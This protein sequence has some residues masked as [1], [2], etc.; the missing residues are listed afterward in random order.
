[1]SI[2][3][4][5]EQQTAMR[6]AIRSVC[7]F[8]V[9]FIIVTSWVNLNNTNISALLMHQRSS[10]EA[11]FY[12][13]ITRMTKG[14]FDVDP[15]MFFRIG[16]YSYGFPYFFLNWLLTLPAQLLGR[17][18]VVIFIMRLFSSL[19]VAGF[20]VLASWWVAKR[21]EDWR[22]PILTAL[23]ILALPELWTTAVWIHP[24]LL[25]CFCTLVVLVIADCSSTLDRPRTLL[26]IGVLFAIAVSTKLQAVV[27]FPAVAVL[28]IWPQGTEGWLAGGVRSTLMR[29]GRRLLLVGTTVVVAYPL[30]NPYLFHPLGR[31]YFMKSVSSNLFAN[32]TNNGTYIFPSLSEK[33]EMLGRT[34]YPF[35]L[36]IFIIA[37]I[38][39]SQFLPGSN[40]TRKQVSAL[41]LLSVPVCIY[42]LATINKLWPHYYLLPFMGVAVM[43]MM[44]VGPLLRSAG[45]TV[46]A[47]ALAAVIIFVRWQAPAAAINAVVD[48][49]ATI[50]HSHVLGQTL[51]RLPRPVFV[52]SNGDVPIPFEQLGLKFYQI[53]EMAGIEI[54]TKMATMPALPDM[55]IFRKDD[56]EII[57]NFSNSDVPKQAAHAWVTN[58]EAGLDRDYLRC[59]ET[60]YEKIL[61]YPVN[62]D[63]HYMLG[64]PNRRSRVQR[65]SAPQPRPRSPAMI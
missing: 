56:P 3:N 35:S 8:S 63:T 32:A 18:D 57:G 21:T 55:V 15:S 22:S 49:S 13:I 26:M 62:A 65:R 7:F 48:D 37:G 24:D 17:S 12:F 1:M 16:F 10:D 64:A 43:L 42:M 29:V 28:L 46:I 31:L 60:E 33:I 36:T 52:L 25:M 4:N 27:F 11:E 58:V 45:G 61:A 44:A 34:Y 47:V 54:T 6:W 2:V 23:A 41:F 53:Y 20:I 30:L 9:V 38:V 14:F 40:R 39:I 59:A 51:A 50:A 5:T 19:P